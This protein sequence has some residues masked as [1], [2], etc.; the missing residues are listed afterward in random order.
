MQTAAISIGI[1]TLLGT[2]VILSKFEVKYPSVLTILSVMMILVGTIAGL[3]AYN[4]PSRC[5]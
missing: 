2:V 5:D 3:V 1:M 4:W